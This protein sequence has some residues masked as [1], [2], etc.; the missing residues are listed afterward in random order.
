VLAT[1][2][3]R[4]TNASGKVLPAGHFLAEEK[5]NELLEEL[6]RFLKA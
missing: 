5:P 6:T 1:W 2:K 4:A 3:E